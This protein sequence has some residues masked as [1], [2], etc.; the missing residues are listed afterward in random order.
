MLF[1]GF[2]SGLLDIHA[3]LS[4]VFGAMFR[5]VVL[6]EDPVVTYWNLLSD[7]F[8]LLWYFKIILLSHDA[9]YFL[10]RISPF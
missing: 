6:L 9:I 1:S 8:E 10:K 2:R 7:P 5:I 3:F 4:V